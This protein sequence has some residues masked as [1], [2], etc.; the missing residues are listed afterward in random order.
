[1]SSHVKVDGIIMTVT[2][3]T[4]SKGLGDVTAWRRVGEVCNSDEG[5]STPQ[6]STDWLDDERATTLQFSTDRLG[7]ER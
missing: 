1:M 5:A 2:D 6:L 3:Q 7:D 4:P